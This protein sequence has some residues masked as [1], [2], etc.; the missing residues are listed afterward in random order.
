M[1]PVKPPEPPGREQDRPAWERRVASVEINGRRVNVAIDRGRRPADEDATFVCECGRIGCAEKVRLQRSEYEAVRDAF[2]RF[3]LVPGHEI[4][5]VDEVVAR[6]DGY[7][8]ARK[9]GEEAVEV[10][11]RSDERA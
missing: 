10:V 5:G 4:A 6:A 9:R 1:G 3:L 8:V 2:N 7:V 11:R